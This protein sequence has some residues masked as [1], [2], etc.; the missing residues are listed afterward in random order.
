MSCDVCLSLFDLLPNIQILKWA[1]NITPKGRN[2]T[3]NI[4]YKI[5]KYTNNKI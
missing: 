5:F 2:H 1:K 3:S 4:H